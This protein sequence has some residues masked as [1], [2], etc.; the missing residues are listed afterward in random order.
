MSF[1]LK[2]PSAFVVNLVS[3]ITNLIETLLGLR[4][5]LRLFNASA[6]APFVRW[7]YETTDPLL[8]PFT[9]M[10]P[11]PKLTGGLLIEF[12]TL[13]AMIFYTVIGYLIVEAVEM[14][15]HLSTKKP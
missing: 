9:G 13:F 12:S 8:S 10:F 1:T 7:I 11:S 2:V 6:N 5:F 3:F 4:I 14:L 15:V